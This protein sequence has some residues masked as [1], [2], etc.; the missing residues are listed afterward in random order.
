MSAPL[1]DGSVGQLL[2]LAH[3]WRSGGLPEA[4]QLLLLKGR[5]ARRARR[6]AL[7]GPARD[8]R[9]DGAVLQPSCEAAVTTEGTEVDFT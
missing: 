9:G 8:R 4:P 2:L 7:R 3:H 1:L 6:R 5:G